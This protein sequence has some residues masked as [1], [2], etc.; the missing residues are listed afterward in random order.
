VKKDRSRGAVWD[1]WE[2]KD[3]KKFVIT[4]IMYFSECKIFKL[5]QEIIVL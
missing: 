3:E 2:K 1:W 4:K 5:Q